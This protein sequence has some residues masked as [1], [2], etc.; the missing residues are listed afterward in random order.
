MYSEL[1]NLESRFAEN[2]EESGTEILLKWNVWPTGTT[3]DPVTG[4]KKLPPDTAVTPMTEC[5]KAF[6]YFISASAVIRQNTEIETGDCI[7]DFPV[8]IDLSTRAD[9]VVIINGEQW[10]TK[11][12]AGKL[13][14]A[15]TEMQAGRRLYNSILLRK[16]T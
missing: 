10:V 12:I 8:E 14:Q 6:L 7:V 2:F 1:D 4:Q 9:L 11:P 3:N 15:W 16:N 13:H 5:I